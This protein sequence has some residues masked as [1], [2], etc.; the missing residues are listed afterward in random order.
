[1]TA[2]AQSNKKLRTGKESSEKCAPR[3]P[4]GPKNFKLRA[5]LKEPGDVWLVKKKKKLPGGM[6]SGTGTLLKAASGKRSV[7]FLSRKK[8]GAVGVEKDTKIGRAW[9]LLP[10]GK[11]TKGAAENGQFPHSRKIRTSRGQKKESNWGQVRGNQGRQT[12][13]SINWVPNGKGSRKMLH[14]KVLSPGNQQG[15][16][17]PWEGEAIA[18][19]SAG[20]DNHWHIHLR[21]KIGDSHAANQ[22]HRTAGLEVSPLLKRSRR[23]PKQP[24][25]DTDQQIFVSRKS[26]AVTE[27]QKINIVCSKQC[28]LPST[29]TGKVKRRGVPPRAAG[30]LRGK[31]AFQPKKA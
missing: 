25:W 28:W 8:I 16:N 5:G 18:V 10:I 4:L 9:G 15:E 7:Q 29:K 2:A 14:Q 20:Y 12:S 27:I 26:S 17:G 3:R 30:K 19:G 23:I 31:R 1:L 22:N 11:G 6:P 13:Q 21:K 24:Q